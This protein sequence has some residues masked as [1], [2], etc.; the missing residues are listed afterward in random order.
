MEILNVL[1]SLSTW[2]SRPKDP[3]FVGAELF[4]RLIDVCFLLQEFIAKI[5]AAGKHFEDEKVI[6][7]VYFK[8]NEF[9][10]ANQDKKRELETIKT[11]LS[12][13]KALL[14]D[15]DTSAE[16]ALE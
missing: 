15:E 16:N 3:F 6:R 8:I 5:D 14:D 13:I 1:R 2:K 12:D 7:A 9:I 11:Y 4:S 10:K